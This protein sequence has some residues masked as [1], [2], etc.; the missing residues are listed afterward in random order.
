MTRLRK[1]VPHSVAAAIATA[2]EKLPADRFDNAKAFADALKNPGYRRDDMAGGAGNASVS[3]RLMS[4]LTIPLGVALV[5]ALIAA[6]WGWMRNAPAAS[7]LMRLP[8]SLPQDALLQQQPG[9]LFVLSQDGSELVYTGPGTG[10]VDLWVRPLDALTATRVPVTSGGDSP[11]LSPDGQVVAFYRGNPPALYTVTLRGGPRQTLAPD[12]TIALGGDF[13]PDGS[14]YF[15]RRG[16]IRRVPAGGGV[17]EQVTRVESA[18]GEQAHG[19]IDVLPNG[20]G[21]VFTILRRGDEDQYDIAA[22]NLSSGKISV[23]FRGVYA[24]YADGHLLYADAAGGLFAIAFDQ[25]ALKTSGTPVPIVAGLSH[26]ENG[27]AHSLSRLPERCC[28]A[29]ALVEVTR[30][31]S[32]WID[33]GERRRSIRQSRVHSK[34]S[35][36]RRMVDMSHLLSGS[37]FTQAYG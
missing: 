13:A 1:S 19:W 25:G 3:A 2:V 10:D 30:R 34:T 18:A 33:K 8:I 24:R 36:S 32:G 37:E 26:S 20:K 4:R 6:G 28:M 16:G 7:P 31:W 9:I 14:I 11:F 23:L 27:L 17:I 15:V 22:L 35:P 29:L 12:S 21:M 5:L